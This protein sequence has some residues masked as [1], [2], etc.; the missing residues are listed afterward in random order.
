MNHV[1]SLVLISQVTSEIIRKKEKNNK[2]LQE[3]TINN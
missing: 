3:N 1:Q 2:H